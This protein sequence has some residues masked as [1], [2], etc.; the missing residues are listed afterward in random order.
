MSNQQTKENNVNAPDAL[1]LLSSHCAFC[2]AVLDSLAKLVKEGELGSLQV[3]NLEQRPDAMQK[4]GVRSVPWVRI[5][6][7][8]LSGAQTLEAL[9]QRIQWSQQDLQSDEK[10]LVAEFDFLLS[11]GQ[12]DKVID[13]IKKDPAAFDAILT[14]LGDPGTVLS[15]RIGLGVVFEEFAEQDNARLIRKQIEELSKLTRHKDPRIRADAY[16]YLGMTGDP[17]LIP[18]FEK[19]KDDE[20]EEVREIVNDSL[21]VLQA[22]GN[23]QRT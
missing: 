5:G 20:N 14:L 15:T 23:N 3:I 7:Y 9:R 18:L 1:M 2:P 12:A 16:H 10:N 11:D 19:G 6:K 13:T 22:S 17:S 4:Y 21:E 8:E